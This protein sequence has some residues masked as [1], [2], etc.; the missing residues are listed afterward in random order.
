MV[1]MGPLLAELEVIDRFG[2]LIFLALGG[3]L[4]VKPSLDATAGNK[5]QC[6]DLKNMDVF[7]ILKYI[8]LG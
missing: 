4:E 3:C 8:P 1:S 7:H 6:V 5:S 2:F